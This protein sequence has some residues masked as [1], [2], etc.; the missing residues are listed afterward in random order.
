MVPPLVGAR[1]PLTKSA[2]LLVPDDTAPKLMLLT[3]SAEHT[4]FPKASMPL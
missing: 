1:V 4:R 3:E 2:L